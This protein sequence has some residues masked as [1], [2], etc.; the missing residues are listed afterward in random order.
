MKICFASHNKNKVREI[1]Q[2]APSG[3]EI[4]GL[5]DLKVTEEIPETGTTM[6]ENS[7]IKASFIHSNFN[8]PVFAD[9][10]GLEVMALNGEP[11]VYSA[12]YAGLEKDA[13]KNMDL[14]LD[15]LQGVE[16]RDAH[17]K[18]VITF[19]DAKGLK[20]QFD[21]I[22][23]GQITKEK[24]GDQGFGYDP[25]FVPE[26]FRNTF[27]EMDSESKNKLSHRAKAFQKLISY[28]EEINE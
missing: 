4:F 10:S 17:F 19:I 3:I 11:G 18:S 6:E 1:A 21:G 27:A 15:N 16:Q 22:V 12:R 9:D 26:G 25:I 23:N 2:L 5:D 20:K 8:V 14:L 28:L 13:Q 7:S 24:R